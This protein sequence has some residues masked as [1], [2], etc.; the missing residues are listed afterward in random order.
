MTVT[1]KVE[2]NHTCFIQM[3]NDSTSQLSFSNTSTPVFE[4]YFCKVSDVYGRSN[5][6]EPAVL[7][8][9]E[10]KIIPSCLISL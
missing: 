5:R 9:Y 8:V 3:V 7:L 10:G 1:E 6:S 4:E 2:S